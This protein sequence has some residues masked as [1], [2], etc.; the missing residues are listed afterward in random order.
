VPS[1]ADCTGDLFDK[2]S[3]FYAISNGQLVPNTVKGFS[4]ASTLSQ[5]LGYS[6]AAG[7]PY[8]IPGCTN[9]SQCVFPD[10]TIP[11]SAFSSPTTHLLQYIPLPNSGPFFTTAAYSQTLRDDKGGARYDQNT[12]WGM[13]SAYYMLD[14]DTLVSP[15]A[16]SSLP[17]FSNQNADRAQLIELGDTTSL[18]PSALNEFRMSF[19]RNAIF[20]NEPIAG[21]GLGTTFSSQGFVEGFDTLGIGVIAPHYVGVLPIGLNEFSFGI[22]ANT[23]K[24]FDNIYQLQDSYSK[25][26][27]T[28]TLKFGGNFHY[29]QAGLLWPNLTS[30][31]N[32]GFN[33]Y[34]TGNDFADFLIGAPVFFA[35]GAPNGFPNRSHYLGL[36][37]QD[38][39]RATRN[40]TLNYGLR[41]TSA[42]SG[43]ALPTKWTR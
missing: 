26:V 10:A 33:G 12:R 6:V 13:I 31:G 8:Y 38:S 22:S 24:Q 2:A 1:A 40:L 30:D 14:D 5:E 35:Q 32:F 39:W 23:T 15:Y 43:T 28:H 4:W 19:M 11:Q 27:G 41:W 37:G 9:S 25:V 18:G 3:S 17:G 34:E 29:D 16:T 42:S 20:Q 7:E 21:Q 36:Y